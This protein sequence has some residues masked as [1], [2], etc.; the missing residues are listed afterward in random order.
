MQEIETLSLALL[1]ACLLLSAFFSGT[2]AAFLATQR[3]RLHTLATRGSATARTAERMM[4]RP[5]R[6][7]ST[8]LVGNNLFNTAAAA[9]ATSIAVSL[10][11]NS[12]AAVLAA[13]GIVT[14]LLL[15]VGEITPKTV[16]SRHAERTLIMVLHPFRVMA[17]VLAPVSFLF[18]LFASLV[19]RLSGGAKRSVVSVEELRTLVMTGVE[20]GTVEQQS[21]ELFR[22][23][24]RFGDR[25]VREV[26]T[27]RSEIAWVRS[28][29]TFAEFLSDY[30]ANAHSRFPV[31]DDSPDQVL[32]IVSIKDLLR[33]QAAG[34]LLLNS[35]VTTNLRATFYVP[36]TKRVADLLQEMREHRAP[37]ALV[38][39]EFGSIAGLVTLRRLVQEVVG[40]V[41]E[42]G[43]PAAFESLDATTI[44][45]D[46]LLH[47]DELA[48]EL[49][50]ALPDGGTDYETVAGFIMTSMGK[51]P[52]EGDEVRHGPYR[53]TVERMD[54]PRIEVVLI[55]REDE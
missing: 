23:V 28:G 29:T 22:N 46:G 39:D 9:L 55:H 8:V 35:S 53:L 54:G 44:Q 12:Q 10:V 26:M 34:E 51:I 5:E 13:T 41:D 21:G 37:V 2:E 30:S 16:A 52:A 3:H 49:H 17:V 15:I 36:E 6:F 42:E 1:G 40:R 19:A 33:S 47:I 14:A 18:G 38:V 25:M 24:F 32:G 11:E 7:L 27:P 50:I 20:D 4:E 31:Y 45:V 48:D 43:E